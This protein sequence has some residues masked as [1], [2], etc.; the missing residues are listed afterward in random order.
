MSNMR[1]VASLTKA[2]IAPPEPAVTIA[3]VPTMLPSVE[4]TEEVDGW[5]WPAGHRVTYPRP[6]FGTTDAFS[7][8][9]WASGGM[10][11]GLLEIV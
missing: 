9:A 8:K 4:V 1:S 7:E 6:P 3:A 2:E 5:A 11:Q 10:L